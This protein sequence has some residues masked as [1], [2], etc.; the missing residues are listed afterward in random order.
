MTVRSAPRLGFVRCL[1]RSL[2][3]P[4]PPALRDWPA[5]KGNPMY[6]WVRLVLAAELVGWPATARGVLRERARARVGGSPPGDNDGLGLR[7]G[8]TRRRVVWGVARVYAW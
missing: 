3:L 5:R 1:R 6:H 2:S 4:P 8:S 7:A